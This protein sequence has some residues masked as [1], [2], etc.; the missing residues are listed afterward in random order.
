MSRKPA[1]ISTSQLREAARAAVANAMEE[2]TTAMSE[3]EARDTSG[4]AIY[5]QPI[6]QGYFPTDPN[7]S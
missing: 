7:L 6:L 3:A 4:G 2:R 1:V 5:Q